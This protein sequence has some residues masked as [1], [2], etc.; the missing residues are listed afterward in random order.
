M[1]EKQFE[2]DILQAQKR[3][4]LDTV[5]LYELPNVPHT[6]IQNP[7]GGDCMMYV[8]AHVFNLI[9]VDQRDKLFRTKDDQTIVG[10]FRKGIQKA[11][12][13]WAENKLKEE[14]DNDRETTFAGLLYALEDED[15]A[16]LNPQ[17]SAEEQ[18]NYY[19]NK[20]VLTQRAWGNDLLWNA[21][22]QYRENPYVEE[23]SYT[24]N[25]FMINRL[26][27]IDIGQSKTVSAPIC[28]AVNDRQDN[29]FRYWFIVVRTTATEY[30]RTEGTGGTHFVNLQLQNVQGPL[31]NF[32]LIY[33][34]EQITEAF[35]DYL[36]KTQ[37]DQQGSCFKIL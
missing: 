2:E 28:L 17:A 32:P 35:R 23:K 33:T 4:V 31:K 30:N 13:S 11:L 37:N 3:S 1:E 18:W 5:P 24:L 12:N 26:Q 10:H 36:Q 6:L 34:S 19:V 16:K 15:R 21:W 29:R 27:G 20:L 8:L 7:A 22:L 14:N 25:C 9:D